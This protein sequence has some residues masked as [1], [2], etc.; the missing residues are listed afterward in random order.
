MKKKL[1]NRKGA[2]VIEVILLI[3]VI[4]IMS[5][6]ILTGCVHESGGMTYQGVNGE[7]YKSGDV[8]Y[9]QDPETGVNY[10]IYSGLREGG[11]CPRYNAD[12]T[13]YTGE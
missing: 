10:V 9:M 12:G 7:K 8:Y 6:I 11:I 13:L 4:V 1:K 3:A 5:L 2:G